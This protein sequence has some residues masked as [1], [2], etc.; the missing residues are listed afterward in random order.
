MIRCILKKK[1]QTSHLKVD[2][3]PTKI[4]SKYVNFADVFFLKLDIELLKH[5]K[6]NDH[7]IKL[8]DD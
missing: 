5:M 8:E 3:A 2:K 4:P 7:V 1:A 6:I